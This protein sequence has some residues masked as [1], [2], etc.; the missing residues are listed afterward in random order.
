MR[1]LFLSSIFPRPYA[2]ARGIYCRHICQCLAEQDDVTVISSRSWPEALKHRRIDAPRDPSG[3]YLIDGLRTTYPTYYYP[4][5]VWRAAYAKFMWASVRRHVVD[6]LSRH[7]PDAVL[8]Y[9]AH[10]DGEVAAR[11]A[12]L[13]GAP[14]AVIIGGSDVLL[15]GKE[16][17]R[18]AA[19]VNALRRVDAVLAV[20]Q[21]LRRNLLQLGI[22]D[23]KIHVVYTGVDP[24]LFCAGDRAE[25]RR[26]LGI[27]LDQKAILYVGN[28]IPLKGLRVL[29]DALN[30][31]G[32]ASPNVHA[33]IVG[34]GPERPVLEQ[35]AAQ[36]GLSA[37]IH[38]CG[39]LRH[40]QLPDYYRAA[41]VT[42][43]A[44]RSEG[45]PNVLRESLAC[46]TPFVATRV[47][48]I[49]EIS[50]SSANRLVNV[51]DPDELAAA[52]SHTIGESFL[53]RRVVEPAPTWHD[54]ASDCREIFAEL[55]S[56]R[57][58][59]PPKSCAA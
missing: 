2:P 53:S 21:D 56:R 38:F 22:D 12:E 5:K 7:R 26:R 18:Q 28:L 49:P 30:K 51:D 9:W 34:N 32:N 24:N 45:I 10:P 13:V 1:I 46:G 19:V 33:Y 23:S 42:V 58:H 20:S 50:T 37:R 39:S 29:L 41:D 36:L 35:R 47:G 27:A 14:S 57:R 54:T 52:L 43:L 15:L 25:A 11:A 44:S 16:R 48:G 4:P 31:I 3:C 55:I 59:A 17:R 40:E 6:H 8:S